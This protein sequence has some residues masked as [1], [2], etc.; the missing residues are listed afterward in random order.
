MLRGD[1]T[2]ERERGGRTVEFTGPLADLVRLAR[3]AKQGSLPELDLWTAIPE[4]TFSSPEDRGTNYALAGSFVRFLF[5]ADPDRAAVVRETLAGAA[6]GEVDVT[7]ELDRRLG[8]VGELDRA[9][10]AW[11]IEESDRET[12]QAAP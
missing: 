10:R 11:L 2:V 8:D 12:A 3:E 7:V 6:R 9:F 1:V 5:E 4:A